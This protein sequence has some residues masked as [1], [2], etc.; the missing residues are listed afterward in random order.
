M[1][2]FDTP[3]PVRLRVQLIAG[4]LTVNLTDT[5]VTTVAVDGKPADAV[6]QT[7]VELA[8]DEL[9]IK[10]PRRSGFFRTDPELQI[11]V[12]AP[13][14][15]SLQADLQSADLVLTGHAADCHIRSGSGDMVIDTV[16]A[17]LHLDAGSGYLR[18][19]DLTGSGAVRSG[20]GDIKIGNVQ[21]S[22]QCNTGSG[23]VQLGR[24]AGLTEVR[25]GSGD[26]VVES[27]SAEL[28]VSTASGDQTVRKVSTGTLRLR[29]A[30]GDV[31]VGVADGTATWLD[32]TTVSGDVSSG[33]ERSTQPQPDEDR[34][35]AHVSTVS[36]D[37]QLTRA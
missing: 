10:G 1:P 20:S 28:T 2:E 27:S 35:A 17:E 9:V 32:I 4:Q 7:R 37:V 11:H 6:E 21:G 16:R 3:H 19:G 31:H 26:V 29:S 13:A 34:V 24:V 30:S 36:G 14:G 18:V 15:S 25:S 23:D 12:T 8:G 5:P 22:L 33:L